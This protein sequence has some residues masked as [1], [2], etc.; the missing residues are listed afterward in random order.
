MQKIT[1]SRASEEDIPYIKEKIKNY[2]L[3]G[4]DI[5]WSQF[6]VL[7]NSGKTVAFVRIKDQGSYFEIASLGVDYYQRRKGFGERLMRYVLKQAKSMGPQKPIYGVTHMPEYFR[8][9]GFQEIDTYPEHL[10]YKKNH[11]CKYPEKI[12]IVKLKDK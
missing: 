7:K 3:D 10:G 6:F 12:K 4:T 2:L 9:F 11:L 1:I 5:D 8:R